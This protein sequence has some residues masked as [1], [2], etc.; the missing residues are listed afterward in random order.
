M[1]VRTVVGRCLEAHRNAA[2]DNERNRVDDR[3]DSFGTIG[4]D[5]PSQCSLVE[6]EDDEEDEFT[7]AGS[8]SEG[9][10]AREVEDEATVVGPDAIARL[11]TPPRDR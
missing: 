11:A 9:G 1:A 3:S 8:D 4:N 2:N 7:D 5:A 6:R 10:S